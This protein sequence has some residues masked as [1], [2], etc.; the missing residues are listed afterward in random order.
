[1]QNGKG[2]LKQTAILHLNSQK[3]NEKRI[4]TI[5]ERT[6]WEVVLA[7]RANKLTTHTIQDTWAIV[8]LN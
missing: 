7:G 4:N 5:G 2:V 1:M 8:M 6:A 3:T